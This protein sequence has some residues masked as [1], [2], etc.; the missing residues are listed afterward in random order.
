V[1]AGTPLL[2]IGDPQDIEIV[3]EMLST[4]AV[5][6]REGADATIEGWGGTTSIPAVVTRIEPGGFTK[7]SALGIE[8][9]RVRVILDFKGPPEA[10]KTLGNDF[11][12]YARVTSWK[13]DSVMRVPL[14]ALFRLGDDWAVFRMVDGEAV[15][16]TIKVGHRNREAAQVLSGLKAGERVILHPS[17]RVHDGVAVAERPSASKTR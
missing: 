8:E 3:V 13:S 1:P 14:S 16:T 15:L 4:D 17:D 7:I 6:I 5:K 9:Q 12:V 11:R 2:E 10:W